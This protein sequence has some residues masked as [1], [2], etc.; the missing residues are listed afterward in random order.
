MTFRYIKQTST[1]KTITDSSGENAWSIGSETVTDDR[2]LEDCAAGTGFD[3]SD[4]EIASDPDLSNVHKMPAPVDTT[5]EDKAA[6]NRAFLQV[7][8][9]AVKEHGTIE[10]ALASLGD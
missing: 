5:V 1:G 7:L 6:A 4:L 8:A 9:D 3:I 2:M 10:A